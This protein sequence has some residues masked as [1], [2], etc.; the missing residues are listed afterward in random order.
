[1]GVE[2]RLGVP[3]CSRLGDG[4]GALQDND[5]CFF[6]RVR[7][8]LLREQRSALA[9]FDANRA[10]LSLPYRRF[11]T[12]ALQHSRQR[13]PAR[14]HAQR[15]LAGDMNVSGRVAEKKKNKKKKKK[16]KKKKS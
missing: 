3:G 15:E 10:H 7:H 12:V 11:R 14:A 1:M 2:K 9:C 4:T 13:S 16:K 8:A 5:L 6:E